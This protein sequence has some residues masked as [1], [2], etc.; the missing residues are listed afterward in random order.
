MKKSLKLLC[1]TALLAVIPAASLAGKPIMATADDSEEISLVSEEVIDEEPQEEE[2]SKASPIDQVVIDGKTIEQ[3]K[4]DLADEN[5][6]LVTLLTLAIGVFFALLKVVE[7]LSRRGLL[8]ESNENSGKIVNL[9]EAISEEKK[10]FDKQY[11]DLSEDLV[12]S[13]AEVKELVNGLPELFGSVHEI[14]LL[15]ISSNPELVARDA[16]KKA[17]EILEKHGYGE[18]E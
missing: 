6:R 3:W 10:N 14:L 5:T 15:M 12:T 9:T 7:I 17:K 18:K 13:V 11:A 1:F 16:Y 8:K 2:T 4:K